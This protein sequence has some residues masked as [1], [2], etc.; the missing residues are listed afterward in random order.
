MIF[1]TNDTDPIVRQRV[2]RKAACE[3]EVETGRREFQKAD[4]KWRVKDVA[5]LAI[6]RKIRASEPVPN[7]AGTGAIAWIHPIEGKISRQSLDNA[8][9]ETAAAWE[10]RQQAADALSTAQKDLFVASKHL[11]D[12]LIARHVHAQQEEQRRLETPAQ[13][14]L[15]ER[16]DIEQQILA[17]R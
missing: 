3:R 15:R 5:E 9:N 4:D 16:R 12:L 14:A 6:V 2:A 7:A 11:E 10:T 13:R 8:R 17:A 1:D